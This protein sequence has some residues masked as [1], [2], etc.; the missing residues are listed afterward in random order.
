VLAVLPLD[1]FVLA[2]LLAVVVEVVEVV[3]ALVELLF[4]ALVL[5][6]APPLPEPV[7][8]EAEFAD[9]RPS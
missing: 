2:A 6:S 8:A 4:V 5:V 9:D 1:A 3:V 7:P